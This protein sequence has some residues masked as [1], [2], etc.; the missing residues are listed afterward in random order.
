MAD[1]LMC[2]DRV[3]S[4]F[5]LLFLFGCS[6]LSPLEKQI[7]KGDYNK[8]ESMIEDGADIGAISPLRGSLLCVAARN[9]QDRLI[10]L[11]VDK[12][13]DVNVRDNAGKTAM[14][15]VSAAETV[16]LLVSLGGDPFSLSENGI[17]PLAEAVRFGRYDAA[18]RLVD[19]GAEDIAWG[20]GN[21]FT[22]LDYAIASCHLRTAE[23]V[24]INGLATAK[25]KHAEA[26]EEQLQ[27]LL[28]Q[29]N[30][31]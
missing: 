29:Y 6:P 19:L 22:A 10:T 24:L 20:A 8:V 15:C 28:H 17:S 30:L 25:I 16:D 31:K 12:G 14:H 23:L 18:R 2:F 9:E 27:S 7:S 5:S 26:C 13:L 1:Y 21:E 3:L 11:L 4:I